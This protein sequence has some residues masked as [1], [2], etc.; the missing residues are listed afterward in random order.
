METIY[1]FWFFP[2]TPNYSVNNVEIS[3][4]L[5]HIC[6]QIFNRLPNIMKSFDKNIIHSLT[7]ISIKI[8]LEASAPRRLIG[9]QLKIINSKIPQLFLS[10]Q[11]DGLANQIWPRIC[12]LRK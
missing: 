4:M 9:E 1:A 6:K 5:F 2:H 10:T 3:H 11:S 7:V 8:L 12:I